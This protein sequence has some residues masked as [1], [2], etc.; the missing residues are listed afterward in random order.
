MKKTLLAL[1]LLAATAA[2]HAQ[3]APSAAPAATAAPAGY[4]EQLGEIINATVRTTDPAVL[5]AQAAKLQRA[6]ALAPADWLPH[7]Y[8]AYAL[9][10][11]AR[12]SK[13]P[14]A[15]KDQL[16]DQADAQLAQAKQLHG[17]ESEL[18]ALQALSYQGRLSIDPMQRGQEY[19]ELVMQ[20]ADLAKTLN[21]ANPRPYLI[22]ANQLYYTPEEYGGGAGRAQPL[23]EAAKA[24]FAAFRPASALAPNWGAEYLAQQLKR[25]APAAAAR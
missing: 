17:D 10:E 19:S 7:Y 18:Q 25:Y 23:Y 13:V 24:K 8:Q 2:A 16:L 11:Q 12:L 9:I 4:A 5:A 6:A 22:E 20:T 3:S 1:A 15:A 14:G 21:P